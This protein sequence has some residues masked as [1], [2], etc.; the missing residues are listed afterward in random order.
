MGALI[1]DLKVR[2]LAHGASTITQQLVR[3]VYLSH[4]KTITRKIK[5]IMLALKLE[6]SLTKTE[7]LEMYQH[8]VFAVAHGLAAASKG[9]FNVEP[10]D[11]SVA[12][13]SLLAAILK[14]PNR[15]SPRNNFD[16][17]MKRRRT[18]LFKMRELDVINDARYRAALREEITVKPAQTQSFSQETKAPYFTSQVV[19]ELVR[20]LGWRKVLTGGYRVITTLDS[21]IHAIARKA[22][23]GASLFKTNPL[24][25]TPDLQGAFVV[26]EVDSGEVVVS[27][28][29]EIINLFL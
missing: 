8:S 5:E 26:R 15:Y 2:R 27:S 17:A 11:L 24:S 19:R 16:K 10:R 1:I 3:N 6:Y 18:V 23:L 13:A 14:A 29:D 28:A 25:T 20:M 7:I 12:Q 21:E 4:E 9:Y 22:F